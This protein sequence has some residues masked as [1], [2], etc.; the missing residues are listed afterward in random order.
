MPSADQALPTYLDLI[1]PT[2]R[3]VEKL[4]GSAQ[5][6]EVT[7]QVLADLGATDEQLA[8]TYEGRPKSVL[9]DRAD[10]ARSYATLGGALERPRRGLFV[11]TPLG[12]EVLAFPEDEGQK[13]VRE[14]DREVR[15]RRRA[16]ASGRKQPAAEAPPE[17]EEIE[18]VEADHS[19][20]EVLLARLHRLSPHGFEEFVVYLLK[21]YAWS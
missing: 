14:L 19:W 3:A 16:R 17:D 2:L 7:A 9:V 18:D 12:R 6:R 20:K 21:T 13:R 8:V 1:L 4:G 11:L 10:W 15:S 5:A